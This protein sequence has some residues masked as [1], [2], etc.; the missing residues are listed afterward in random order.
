MRQV[1]VSNVVG[2]KGPT[3]YSLPAINC[4]AMAAPANPDPHADRAL[5]EL[6][7]QYIAETQKAMTKK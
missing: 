3:P 2:S 5:I 7:T 4:V 1:A 6:S